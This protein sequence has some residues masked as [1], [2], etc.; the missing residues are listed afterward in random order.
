[1]NANA[2][3]VIRKPEDKLC[4]EKHHAR[5]PNEGEPDVLLKCAEVSG[6]SKGPITATLKDIKV[7]IDHCWR[8][9]NLG[10]KL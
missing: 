1:M 9:I 3:V 8:I 2:L 5:L 7:N 4:S 6:S 10:Q